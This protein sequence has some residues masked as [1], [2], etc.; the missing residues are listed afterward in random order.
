MLKPALLI[1]CLFALGVAGLQAEEPAAVRRVMTWVPPYAVD[2]CEKRLNESFAGVGMKDGITHLGLQFWTPTGKGGLQSVN[3]FGLQPE[4]VSGFR[5]WGDKHGVR[6]LL[7]VYNAG[8]SGWNWDLARSAFETNRTQFVKALVNETRRL[9]LDGV[10]IDFEGKE[11]DDGSKAPFVRFVAEL[12]KGLHAHGKELSVDSFAHKWNAPNQT[13]WTALL[14]HVDGLIVMGYSE[15]GAG[16]KGWRSY[17]FVKSAAGEHAAK[18][19]LGMP[20]H[21][22]KWQD[23]AADKHLQWVLNDGSVGLA[24]WDARLRDAAW[25]TRKTWQTIRRIKT[26]ENSVP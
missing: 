11:E 8:S 10:D 5:K 22:G 1:L 23:A 15:T 9:K 20:G 17:Q 24:I 3:R 2:D 19:L 14:P 16:A 7:C 6:V 4:A 12:S 21:S 26:G 18:L 13:W 25:R